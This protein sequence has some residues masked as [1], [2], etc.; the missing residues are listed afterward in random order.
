MAGQ[1]DRAGTA[2]PIR[3]IAPGTPAAR[4]G[5]RPESC[6]GHGARLRRPAPDW[7][8]TP[9]PACGSATSANGKARSWPNWSANALRTT[10]HG[11]NIA[12]ANC[13]MV[14]RRRP[15]S[16]SEAARHWRNGRS[17]PEPTQICTC[18]R[19]AHGSRR[20][21]RPCWDWGYPPRFRRRGQH[22]QRALGAVRRSR[23]AR[24]HVAVAARRLQSWSG[25][26]RHRS[27]GASGPIAG[28]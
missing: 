10:V 22:G 17:A 25:A 24:R 8:C 15:P 21:C 11:R 2:L 7:S 18:S 3:R 14:P 28:S 1:A 16:A 13:G 5:I 20:P 19:M 6:H 9:T 26:R 4:R 12:V 23:H 27:V